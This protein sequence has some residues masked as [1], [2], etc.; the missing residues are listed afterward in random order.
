[1][2]SMPIRR[3]GLLL[4]AFSV[5]AILIGTLVPQAEAARR[6]DTTITSGPPASTT[7]TTASVA[8]KSNFSTA[9]FQCRLDGA[10][11]AACTSPKTMSG[12]LPGSHTFYVRAVSSRGLVDSSPATRTWTVTQPVTATEPQPEPTST[13][14]ISGRLGGFETGDFSEF[15]G[16]SSYAATQTNA[17]DRAYEGTRSSKV[18]TSGTENSFGR[19]WYD[20]NWN[21]G[22]DVWYGSAFYVPVRSAL[23]YTDLMRWDNYATYGNPG[24]DVGGVL[25]ENGR[26]YV[27]RQDYGGGNFA[28]VLGPVE[29]PEGRWFHLEVHQRL[30]E[31]N[32]EALT[33]LYVDGQKVGSS[34][35]ANSR[36]R[37][38]NHMR[39][40]YVNNHRAGGASTL[41]YDR[42]SISDRQLGP[43]I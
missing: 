5:L 40:G 18:V 42:V 27:Q 17:T 41:W 13:E 32:G 23:A 31:V 36:G 15:N 9:S 39:F 8:F 34:T 10:V 12:L 19:S 33:E 4:A 25:V 24:G 30:S 6:P 26:M 35:V 1:M 28:Y 2:L 11:W 14:P 16:S 37:V 43:K 29:V 21:K 3:V 20:V 22:S 38:I 7:E